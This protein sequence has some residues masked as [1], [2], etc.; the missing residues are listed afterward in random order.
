MPQVFEQSLFLFLQMYRIPI[1]RYAVSDKF[2]QIR[3]PQVIFYMY[4]IN[5]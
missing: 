5:F 3:H 1:P 2:L 4:K